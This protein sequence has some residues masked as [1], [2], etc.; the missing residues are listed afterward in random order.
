M[1]LPQGLTQADIKGFECK[2]AIYTEALDES[3]DDLLTIKENIHLKDGRIIPHVR[4]IQN[5]KREFWVTKEGLRNH[6]DKK[7]FEELNK[8]QV[9]KTTQ[10]DL[11]RTIARALGR[12][13]IPGGLR[14]AARSP[15]LY[16]CDVTTPVLVKHRYMKQ[17]PDC[18]SDNTLAV[19]D[20]ESDVV[21][22]HERPIVGSLTFKDKAI[23]IVDHGF[24]RGIPN[25]EAKIREK[26]TE[27]LGEY[28]ISRKIKL[29]IVLCDNIAEGFVKLFKRA[30]EWM[31]DIITVWNINYD[32][33]KILELLARNGFDAGDILS[34]PKVPVKFRKF[35]YREGPAVKVT[36]SGRSMTLSPAERWH[37]V[38]CP[39]SFYFLD[40]MCVYQKIRS[41]KGK[42]SSYALD[43]ILQ[44]HLGIRKLK[45]K[46]ADEHEGLAW[47]MFMQKNYP[48]E[49]CIYN[50]F[51]CISVELL[52]EKTTDLSRTVSYLCGASEYSKFNSQPR[53]TCDDLHFFYLE[54]GKVIGTT[55]DQMADDNDKSVVGLSDWIVALP[56]H[57]VDDSQ[58]LKVIKE[59]P[60]IHTNLRA[61]VADL[62]IAATY[63]TGELVM[64][65]S[66][67]TTKRELCEIQGVSETVR[68]LQGINL[69]GGHTN[70]V[71][72]CVEFYGAP[73]FDKMLEAFKKKLET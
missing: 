31:P 52:D 37:L 5:Y 16:G 4:L 30:H 11:V 67:D 54:H 24:V 3:R 64:N 72:L 57:L 15:Y 9:F 66:K 65:I 7:E 20:I 29:E 48:I 26:F 34:D 39:S 12:G 33:P 22:G 2:H 21:E 73:S 68:R 17:Y 58:G 56:A 53:R 55:S 61:H 25:P 51:D 45:F 27:Y 49:Y 70:A 32:M 60:D 43:A 10:R 71:E 47:H 69:T 18:N 50:L 8:L 59:C 63:P 36:A 44:K 40:A 35:R 1:D 41:A 28:E 62:D 23:M 46:E 38:E 19:V 6:Q 13:A 42:E 14:L